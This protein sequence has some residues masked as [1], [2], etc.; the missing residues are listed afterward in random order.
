[1]SN[2]SA[3]GPTIDRRSLLASGALAAVA[4]SAVG[5]ADAA[6]QG[7]P[8]I[9]DV[10]IVGAGLAGLTAARDLDRAGNG[11]FAVLEARD[12]VGG[13]VLNHDLAGGHFS[14][15]GG[16][17]IGPGQTAIADLARELDIETFDSIYDGRMVFRWGS[18]QVAFESDGSIEIEAGLMKR[19]DALAAQ[20]PHDR[21]WTAPNARELDRMSIAQWLARQDVG[22]F[23]LLTMKIASVLTVGSGIGNCS[24]LYYLSML[25]FAGGFQRLEAQKG[26]A[27]QTRFVGGSQVLADKMAEELGA[28]VHLGTAVKA[29]RNWNSDIVEVETTKGLLRARRVIM[30]LSP[31]LCRK[32]AFAPALP[33]ARR[34]L[35]DRW[36]THAP[37][38]KSAMAYK[39]PFWFDNGYNGQILSADGPLIWAY[40]NSPPQQ[41]IGVIN[42][43]LRVGE[44]SPDHETAKRQLTELFA[45]SMDDNRFLE[46]TEFHLHDWGQEEWS[47][48]CVSPM[49]P[50]LLTSPL[51]PALNEP[52]GR[53]CWSG[54][55]TGGI[56]N[57][58]M[59]GAVRSGRRAALETLQA[60]RAAA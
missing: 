53:L 11:S 14:E 13:R 43:F 16:Q 10:I 21:P 32:I 41:E 27:Q 36:P 18:D 28:K 19:L 48:S 25:N 40:D 57:G 59:D 12:R 55:E 5:A 50:G 34:A 7:G 3:C 37:M 46:P 9:L 20:V 38:C 22:G 44:V 39:R 33:D 42:A 58:Y 60:L 56:W 29:I 54:T 30:A 1:M 45:E 2:Q 23:D 47:V 35:Q 6:A 52:C 49:P 24:M 31:P 4:V 26:G 8:E 15:A 17:W 51:M